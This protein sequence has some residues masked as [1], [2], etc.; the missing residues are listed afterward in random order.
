MSLSDTN[1]AKCYSSIVTISFPTQ[2]VLL[3]MTNEVYANAESIST[4]TI[5]GYTYIDEI[6]FKVDALSSRRVRFYK[7]D[8]TQN[9]TYPNGNNSPII[10]LTS[11]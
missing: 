11:V 2:T 4:R 8:K 3:D 5:S 9:Y 10:T 6:T 1:K 7:R